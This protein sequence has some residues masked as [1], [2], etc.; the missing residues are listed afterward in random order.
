MANLALALSERQARLETLAARINAGATEQAP[1]TLTF[2]A[3]P[4]PASPDTALAGQVVLAVVECPIPFEDEI[5]NAVLTTA[6]FDEVLATEAGIAAWARLRDSAGAVKADLT[7]GVEGS[8]ANIEITQT[9]FYAG[10]IVEIT[11]GTIAE[12]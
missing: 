12:A 11:S 4:Q 10:V 7:V 8:G 2:Y 6:P 3:E 5:V 9:Q 1:A